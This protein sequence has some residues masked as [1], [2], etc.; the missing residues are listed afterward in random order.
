VINTLLTGNKNSEK[1]NTPEEEAGTDNFKKMY[2]KTA[3]NLI[4]KSENTNETNKRLFSVKT[5][6]FNKAF[7]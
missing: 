5:F 7:H 6:I 1:K 3:L 4:S 2:S